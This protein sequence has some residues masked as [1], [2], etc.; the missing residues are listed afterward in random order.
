VRQRNSKINSF[1]SLSKN[2]FLTSC[3]IL[4]PGLSQLFSQP[5][6]QE[7][8]PEENI[9]QSSLNLHQWGAINSFHGLPSEKVNAIAQTPDG[10]LW[11][12]TDNGLARF[13]GRRV[14][15]MTFADFSS[16]PVFALKVDSSGILWIGTRKGAFYRK[17]DI[18]FS[19]KETTKYPIRSIFLDSEKQEVLLINGNG[20]VFK[21][22]N[23]D[24]LKVETILNKSL[25]IR[26]VARNG[27]ET[28]FGTF[29]RGLVKLVGKEV[30]PIITRPHPYFINILAQD[31]EG[32]IWV[33]ARSSRGNSGLFVSD[34]LPKLKGVGQ[35]LGTVNTISFGDS[36]DTWVGTEDRGAYLFVGQKFRKRF[37]FENTSGGLRSN[38]ILATFVDREG[39]VWFGTNK[40]VSRYDPKSLR[41]ER[42]S[43]NA[44]SNFVRTLFKTKNG[45]LLAGTNRGLFLY[46]EIV[47]G[48]KPV[49]GLERNTIYSIFEDKR[50][51]IFVGTPNGLLGAVDL[52]KEVLIGQSLE[53]Q[54]IRAIERFQG[55]IFLALMGKGVIKPA[56]PQETLALETD[57][58]SLH[59]ENNKLLWIGTVKNG[60]FVYDGKNTLQKE[61]LNELKGTAV[62]SITGNE[63]EGIWFATDKGLYLFKHGKMDLVL[64]EKNIR[65][66]VLQTSANGDSRIWC[67]AVNGLFHITSTKNFG[68][69]SSRIDI[70]QGL[71]SQNVFAILPLAKDS[72]LFGTN[73]GIV[74]YDK[75]SVRPLITPHRILS[76]REHHPSELNGGIN[77][78]YPQNS[79]SIE[80][81]AISSRTFSEQF[82]YSY[83]LFDSN[84]EVIK[85]R[86]SGDAQFLM[87][88]LKPDQYRIEIRAYDKDLVV[89]KPLIFSFTIEKAPFPWIATILGVLLVIAIAALIWAIFS[90]RKIFRTSKELTHANK[91][92]NSARLDL[93]NEAER[94]RHRISRDLHDQTLADLRHLLL[95]SDEMPKDRVPD[96]RNEIENVSD[97][98][99]RIC[100]DLSPSVLENIGF[101][102]ALEWA[103]SSA[104]EQVSLENTIKHEF[105]C[106]ENLEETLKLSRPEQIQ[107][108]RVAQEV[109]SNIVRHSDAAQIFLSVTKPNDGGV[110]MKITDDS[111]GFDS[112]KSERG[113]GLSNIRARARLIEANVSWQKLPDIG[114]QFKLVK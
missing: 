35:N 106:D 85:K 68:W 108:Y 44:Q 103:L 2:V 45:K 104:V 25:P 73:R 57:A 67:A 60:V 26:S 87:D 59:N 83:L 74:R 111:S 113:R 28:L 109:L 65:K 21:A 39:V 71:A 49:K 69:I 14:Q 47:N 31:G 86:F 52:S 43:E 17:N 82:Q 23:E 54:K 5:D 99:R 18:F 29:N 89:S 110:V 63:K 58:I 96:F 91:E 93:A 32:K 62:R 100:E 16:Q 84:D 1:K 105:S 27:N 114:M 20:V 4:F 51:G 94:E 77:L 40:G 97:E 34:G 78:D 6:A 56:E 3:L 55:N 72:F 48:W 64:T 98:I 75:T 61:E 41:N 70:E 50:G 37:T 92:L 101:T 95:M 81:T 53:D 33:G 12:G 24:V 19:I 30:N 15:T 112:E 66:V 9:F 107:I 80:V 46:D 76:Q 102:A 90:Q 8:F 7:K 22:E 38:R 10:F 42:I 13:D 11:F 36:D 88:K 79:L